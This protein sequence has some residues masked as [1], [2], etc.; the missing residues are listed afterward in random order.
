M[1]A[2]PELNW[3]AKILPDNWPAADSL[4]DLKTCKQLLGSNYLP[5]AADEK[6]YT[7]PGYDFSRWL[8]GGSPLDQ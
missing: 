5:T 2:S 6:L 8:H 4:Q 7:Q 1:L 3:Y